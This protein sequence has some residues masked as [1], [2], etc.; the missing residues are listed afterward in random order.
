MQISYERKSPVLVGIPVLEFLCN[1]DLVPILCS[2]TGT[3]VFY[4]GLEWLMTRNVTGE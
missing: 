3:L 4:P 1:S 2:Q